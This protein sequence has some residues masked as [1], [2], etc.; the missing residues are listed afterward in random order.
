MAT[1]EYHS[2]LRAD[3]VRQT[4]QRLLE[5]ASQITLLDLGRI[6][7][8]AVARVAGV[9]ERTAYR[10]FPTVDEL[11][12]AFGEFLE[13]RFDAAYPDDLMADDLPALC[14][15]WPDRLADSALSGLMDADTESPIVTNSR[16]RRYAQLERALADLVPDATDVQVRQL[17][18][19]FGA[20]L[21]PEPYRRG[22]RIFDLDP[23]DVAPAPS[24]AVQVLIDALRE[25]ATPWT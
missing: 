15:R 1:S 22:K 19:V 5:A 6:T 14:D 7:H 20:L 24:W 3:Q 9:S 25:G 17:V 12:R 2:P 8:A 21:A 16:R 18:V 4:R 13:K 11:H 10:H 23:T